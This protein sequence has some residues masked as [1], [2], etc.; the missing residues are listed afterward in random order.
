M[1]F[2]LEDN[3]I[4]SIFDNGNIVYGKGITKDK[5]G[6]IWIGSH[7]TEFIDTHGTIKTKKGTY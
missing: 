2:N 7:K 5:N 4:D 3:S 6:N 1:E